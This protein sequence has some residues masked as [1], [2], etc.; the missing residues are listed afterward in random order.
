ML[1]TQLLVHHPQA[2]GEIVRSTPPWVGALL[3]FLVYL[4]ISAARTRRVH[5][6][7]LALIPLAMGGLA[8]WGELSAFG[9][10]G[11][12]A[13]LLGL[14]LVSGALVIAG[15]G[16]LRAP[17]GT[18]YDAASRSF[19]L[20]GSWVPLVLILA[21]FLMKYG[22]GVQLAL[23]PSLAQDNRFALVVTV[24]YGALSGLF[25]ARTLRVVRL[26]TRSAT[27]GLSGQA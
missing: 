1:L 9:G 5:L 21:V 24:L 23:E 11:H 13:G 22:I 8:L 15:S 14:W 20:P 26:A 4:G 27:A 12:L 16:T 2:V 17:A 6:A 10:H 25:A 19:D 3:A 7:R 18:R